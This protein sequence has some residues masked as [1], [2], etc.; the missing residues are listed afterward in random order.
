MVTMATP[1]EIFQNSRTGYHGF[2][3]QSIPELVTMVTLIISFKHSRTGY[4]GCS[5]YII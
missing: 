5:I 1:V 3:D 2:F 4:R